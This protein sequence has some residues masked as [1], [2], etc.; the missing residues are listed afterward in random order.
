MGYGG[1]RRDAAER[2]GKSYDGGIINEDRLALG[3]I[4]IQAKRWENTV[5][6]HVRNVFRAEY[7]TGDAGHVVP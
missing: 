6:R 3:V 5:G 4:Y 2:V 1:S 7:R